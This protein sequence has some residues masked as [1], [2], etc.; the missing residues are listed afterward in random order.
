MALKQETR[1][2]KLTTPLGDDVLLLT[3][4]QGEESI[5]QLFRFQLQ[6]ISEEVAVEM[7]DLVGK[8][9]SFSV[10]MADGSPRHY[11]GFISQF[12][13][14]GQHQGRR[15]YQ[16]EVVPWLWFLTQTTDC[17]IFQNKSVPE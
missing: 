15:S 2:L 10:A 6:M 12:G 7:K 16:A 14:G 9:V 8:N 3:A 13:L 5:S 4:F 17:R 11:N 1:S